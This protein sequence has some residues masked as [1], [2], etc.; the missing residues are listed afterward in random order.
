MVDTLKRFEPVPHNLFFEQIDKN[1][2]KLSFLLLEKSFSYMLSDGLQRFLG[3]IESD[4]LTVS[5][6]ELITF[7][8]HCL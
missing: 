7:Y 1:I 2:T 5:N 4:N 3:E 8:F 6:S